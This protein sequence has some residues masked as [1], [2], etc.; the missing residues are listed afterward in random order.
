MRLIYKLLM[1]I[2][3]QKRNIYLGDNEKTE[4]FWGDILNG[5]KLNM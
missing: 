2:K 5:K 3:G 4:Y 1:I